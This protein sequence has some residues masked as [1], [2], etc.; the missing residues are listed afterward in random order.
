MAVSG[1]KE[2][3]CY[4]MA[5]PDRVRRAPERD[6]EGDVPLPLPVRVLELQGAPS[7][8]SPAA[9]REPTV[10][11]LERDQ[12]PMPAPKAHSAVFERR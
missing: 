2:R 8:L 3:Q 10:G 1:S 11:P 7:V 12:S 4:R 9:G 5:G 6:A